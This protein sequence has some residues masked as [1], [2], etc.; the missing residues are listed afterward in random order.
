MTDA[1]DTF[2]KQSDAY[3]VSRPRYP[4]GL[5]EW[6]LSHCPRREAAWDVATGNGQAAVDLS[7]HFEVVHASDIS[8]EQV[9]HGETRPNIVY[10]AGRAE[11]SSYPEGLFDLV[12]VA[13]A[14]HWFEY[15]KFWPEVA[16]VSKPGALFCAWGYAWF[17]CD[18]EVER[19]LIRPFRQLI[20]PFWATNNRILWRGYKDADIHFPY[21]RL[22]TPP[23]AIEVNWTVPQII[24]Y[25]QT[26]SAYKRSREDESV[27]RKLEKLVE[28]T[29]AEF[30]GRPPVSI[31]M[32]LAMVAG[33]I[34]KG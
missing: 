9:E 8:R 20:E 28:T 5:Y 3:A 1:R 27:A 33:Y 7:P 14:L 34:R 25:M 19:G 15:D 24:A 2:A 30:S 22:K 16:R 4:G 26:W 32:P 12:A 29:T 11:E 31:T 18:P 10:S 17:E 6:L 23:L 21:E 13:Q